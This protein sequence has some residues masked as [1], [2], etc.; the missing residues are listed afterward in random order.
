M[1]FAAILSVTLVPAVAALLIRGR[2]RP[3]RKTRSRGLL[4]A[5]TAR[6]AGSRSGSAGRSS[7]RPRLL[8]AATVPVVRRLGSEFMPPLNEGTL[9][10]MPTAVPGMSEASAGDVLQRMDRVLK[11]FPE[12]ESVFGK[13]GRFSTPTD[14]APLEMFETVVQLRPRGEWPQGESWEAL[15]SKLDGAMQFTGMPNVWWMPIQTRTEMLATGVR[16]PLGIQV[17]GPDFEGIDQVAR[18]I[19]AALLQV[20]GTRSAFAE[21]VGGGHYVDFDVDRDAAARYG[22]NVGGRRG[23]HRDRHRR[24]DRHHDRR[25]AR[26]LPGH[27]ALR[28]RLPVD[29]PDL[30]RVLVATPAGAQNPARPGGA[31]SCRATARR[32]C[33]TKGASS[34]PT[35]SSTPSGRSPT[36]STTPARRSPRA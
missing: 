1:G 22:L 2:I 10:Y 26:A 20:P 24:Q 18:Q 14:P 4:A 8:V 35:S 32:C 27:R 3:R 9:L 23:R 25:G 31:A 11:T 29:L 34:T 15:V 21:R 12:V 30:E 17:L 28:A 13:A 36:T 19:E 5:S 16:S 7:S 6:S 33:A